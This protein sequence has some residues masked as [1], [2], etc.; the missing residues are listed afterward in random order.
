[1]VE[2]KAV[3]ATGDEMTEIAE[4]TEAVVVASRALVAVAA[5]SIAD[6]DE[7]VTLPQFRALVVLATRGP[8][9]LRRMAETLA[10][11]ASTG[12]RMCDRL[13]T[14]R[15]IDR[16]PSAGDRREITLVLT[17]T[18]RRLVDEVTERRRREIGRIMS[19]VAPDERR[20]IARALQVFAEAS[21]EP[22][23]TELGGAAAF[24]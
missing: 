1:M 8:Q 6:V 15:L 14:K 11:H 12:T 20:A 24:V 21:G 4:M 22:A 7:S 19:R 9:N 2:G 5:R 13:V 16:V 17:E 3:A 10:V 18:G 23:A